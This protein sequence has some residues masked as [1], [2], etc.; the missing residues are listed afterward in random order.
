MF[1][2][3]DDLLH[4]NCCERALGL[5]REHRCDIVQFNIQR[6]NGDVLSGSNQTFMPYAGRL[7]GTPMIVP[8]LCELKFAHTLWGKIYRG[9]ICRRAAEQ[10]SD[11]VFSC[12]LD[13]YYTFFAISFFASS[14][15]GVPEESLYT[16]R[17][18][19]GIGSGVI[20]TLRSVNLLPAFEDF[21]RRQNALGNPILLD[22][23]RKRL[24]ESGV[25]ILMRTP[26]L[27][28]AMFEEALKCWGPQILFDF[29]VRL[30]VFNVET[31]D[32]NYILPRLVNTVMQQGRS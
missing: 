23:L 17:E 28:P 26:R 15:Y 24:Y 21:L 31:T 18:Y 11:S 29:I 3:S 32:R 5:I 9:D 4:P 8:W 1:A 30:G 6:L 20:S 16:Y 2:D 12:S 27:E 19:I 10:M 7:E 14:Y 22:T 13:D 25:G